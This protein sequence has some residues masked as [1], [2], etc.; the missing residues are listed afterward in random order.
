MLSQLD[1]FIAYYDLGDLNL[2]SWEKDQ[3]FLDLEVLRG[4]RLIDLKAE[5]TELKLFDCCI[6]K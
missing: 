4:D 6:V 3:R 2:F 5:P 1:N